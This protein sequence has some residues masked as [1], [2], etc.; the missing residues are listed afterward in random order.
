MTSLHRSTF[1]WGAGFVL[2]GIALALEAAAVW[3]LRVS[4]LRIVVPA[5]LVLGGVILVVRGARTPL[6]GEP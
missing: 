5:L 6:D 3:A 1:V 4:D 2:V